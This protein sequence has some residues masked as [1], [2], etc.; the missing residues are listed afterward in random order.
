MSRKLSVK[1]FVLLIGVIFTIRLLDIQVFD[2]SYVLS[3]DNNALRNIIQYPPRGEV[4][5]RNG[6]FLAQSRESYDLMMVPSSV[7]ALDTLKMCDIFGISKEDLI[8]E[9]NKAK[10]YSR[11]RASVII[12][13][14]SKEIKFRF[15][16]QNFKGFYIQYRTVRYYPYRTAGNLLGYVGEVSE[17]YINN[18]PY[19]RS[20]DFAGMSGIESAYEDL[21]RGEKGVKLELV[22]VHGVSQGEYREGSLDTVPI[23]GTSIISSID[24]DLQLLGEEL[25]K[26]KVGAIVAIEP[27]SG[28]ILAMISSPTYNPDALIG[29]DRAK[30]Y[31]SFLRDPRRPL[32]NR[33]VMSSYPPGSTFKLATGLIGL[34]E[35]VV[36]PKT[37]YSCIGGVGYTVGRGVGCHPHMS[38]AD[39]LYSIQTSCNAYYC[40]VYR[41]IIDNPKYNSHKEGLDEWRS[42]LLSMGFGRTLD[43]DFTGELRGFI[44]DSKFYDRMYKGGRWSSL[45]N[46]S[47]SIGQGEVSITPLQVANFTATIANRGYYIVPHI[48]KEIKDSVNTINPLYFEKQYT[49]VDTSH[50]KHIVEG[51][52]RAVNV[53]GSGF[54]ARVPGL[55]ICGKTGTVQNRGKD[56][57]T[58][59]AFAPKN[60]PKIAIVV[61][62]EHGGFGSTVALPIASLMIEQYLTDTIKRVELK[63]YI[64]TYLI[65]YPQY[66]KK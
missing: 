63:E 30:H 36:T 11:H 65:K 18:D 52:Y 47:N 22:N 66:E 59:A 61:Y 57:S 19:Y 43:S 20:G 46:I 26:D 32:F 12:K 34:Q 64:K 48:I 37:E 6:K 25:M 13:Q 24:L 42:Y 4:Y 40:H 33:A 8:K 2:D 38:P 53:A 35:G 51:M 54:R 60:D 14:F 41:N 44:P 17:R 55:D 16:E 29:R 31:L 50:Y 39:F 5:D 56:H 15:D 21:L 49:K 58:F 62:V 23:P 10:R 45:T 3:A 27:K 7:E 1:L 9:F 28:E